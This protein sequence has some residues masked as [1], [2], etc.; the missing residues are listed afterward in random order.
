MST[1]GRMFN[2]RWTCRKCGGISP[3]PKSDSGLCALCR[4]ML[5]KW[6]S[7]VI[8]RPI[9]HNYAR[10]VGRLPDSDSQVPRMVSSAA[11]H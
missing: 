3:Y 2:C 9:E 10:R 1:L 4:L 7:S 6:G 11:R 5:S 8:G